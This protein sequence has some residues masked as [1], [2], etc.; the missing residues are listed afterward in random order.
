[1]L[2]EHADDA[3]YYLFPEQM[4]LYVGIVTLLLCALLGCFCQELVGQSASKSL[5][6]IDAKET[7]YLGNMSGSQ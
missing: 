6:K 5:N 2:N 3:T 1:M 7:Y 4:K